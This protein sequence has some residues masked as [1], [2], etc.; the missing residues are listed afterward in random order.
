[1][2]YYKKLCNIIMFKNPHRYQAK[3]HI[4][5][6]LWV[7]CIQ[8][9]LWNSLSCFMESFSYCQ[10]CCC[11]CVPSIGYRSFHWSKDGVSVMLFFKLQCQ[12]IHRSSAKLRTESLDKER[13]LIKRTLQ[14]NLVEITLEAK[15]EV[16]DPGCISTDDWL[17]ESSTTPNPILLLPEPVMW[18]W[19]LVQNENVGSLLKKNY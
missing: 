13:A 1:M 7:Y 3:V 18:Q 8:L 12:F 19:G 14:E 16:R 9:L 6:I 10:R 15:A 11:H 4:S 5:M 17:V 2:K